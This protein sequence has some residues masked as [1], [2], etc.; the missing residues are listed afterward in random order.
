M[1]PKTKALI[2]PYPNNPTGAIMNRQELEA[3]ADVVRDTNIVVISDEIYCMLTYQGEH[4]SFA[5]I[6]GMRERT[7]VVDGFSSPML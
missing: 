7:I 2:L 1:T 4:V 3:I 5:Q 6:D